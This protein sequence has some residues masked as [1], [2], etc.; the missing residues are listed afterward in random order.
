MH[1]RRFLE[2]AGRL[3]GSLG[4]ASPLLAPANY[5]SLAETQSDREH[6][7]ESRAKGQPAKTL[8][9]PLDSGWVIYTDPQNIGRA[10]EW[11][12]T[13]Q[14]GAKATRVPSIIQETHPGY[15]GVVWYWLEFD[16]KRNPW[17]GGRYLI[18]FNAVDYVGHVWLNG[19]YLGTHEGGETPFTLDATNA[20][21]P[22]ERNTLSLRVLNPSDQRID[23]IVLAET[24]HK[25]K[26]IKF[27]NGNTYDYGGI[28][29]PVE[30]LLAPAVRITDLNVRPD[31]KT[32]SLRIQTSLLN[33]LATPSK[34]HVEFC[35]SQAGVNQPLLIDAVDARVPAR[36]TIIDHEV[37]IEN[38]RL[39]DINDPQLYTLSVRTETSDH[40]GP[41]EASTR[42][43]FRDFR[44]VR[45]YFR[46]NG[47]RIL[48]RSTHT[49]NLVPFGQV[50]PPPGYPDLLRRDL[51]YA[52]ASGFNTVRFI[53]G[54]A[55]PYQL[56]LCD[57]LGLMVYEESFASWL[58]K[59]SP[60]MKTRFESSIREMIL[61][62]RNHASLVIWGVLNET[63]DGPVF[64]EGV[65][66]LETVRSVDA[67]RLVL[68]SSGRFDGHLEV[69]S[70]SNPGG[71]EWEAAW[72]KEAP[73]AKHEAMGH[74]SPPGSGDF[75]FYPTVPQNPEADHVL[76]T[77]GTDSKPVFLS[78]Y[79]IGSMMDVIHEMKMFV[80][81]GIPRDAEDFVLMRS[82]AG[83]FAEDWSRFGMDVVY[84]NPETMLRKSQEA[85]AR[86][87]LLGFNLIRSNPNICGFNLT[88]M[89]DHAMTG[90]GL[91]RSWRDW[92]PGAF[93]ATQDGWA[94]VRWCLFVEP[95]HTY[96]GRPVT[97]EAVL[98]NEDAIRPGE[99][100]V[101]FRVWGS[102][103][104][105]WAR[106]MQISVP[107]VK[108]GE[109]GPLALPVLKENVIL[110]AKGGSYELVPYI[111]NG[112]APPETSWE[113]YLSDPASLPRVVTAATAWHLPANVESW[114]VSRG[115]T[116][117]PLKSADPKERGVIL[118]GDVSSD[119]PSP[120]EWKELATRMA[121]GSTVVFLSPRAF[122]QGPQS[123]AWMPLAN[124]GRI[125][126]F[127]DWL[128]H[129]DCVAKRHPV[130]EGLQG[131]GILDFYYYG[132]M[133]PT[134]LF[135][136][137]DPP[138][139]VI[140]AAFAAGYSTPGGYA[141]GILLGSYSFGA[142]EFFL[143]S[144]PI[145][146]HVDD[147]PVADRLLLNLV[148]Y[149]S[150]KAH[151][152]S[153]AVPADFDEVLKKIGYSA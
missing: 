144:F 36:Q 22:N 53:A 134:Y 17:R 98:A 21:R 6:P 148:Q 7:G 107:E 89:L 75:H 131:D 136:G 143:N 20:V 61:R 119:P 151:G 93:D 142:G 84:P 137:Q 37:T 91:W 10:Q 73:G 128:Y 43:G 126:Q 106:D 87:R 65:A 41:D 63:V 83:R 32:G 86:H 58:L 92:K 54:V 130:F 59:D 117:K 25:N 118:V 64:R 5:Q 12:H 70:V 55:Y 51:V 135:D 28:I 33:T 14:P 3:G 8:V 132:P 60:Q 116:V 29:G 9:V 103:G 69:G 78:E 80:Q 115:A 79:G 56:D 44:V 31:W 109:D 129:K 108:A 94:P 50:I 81:A 18:R 110:N 45:G 100:P 71:T 97:L 77:L 140:A 52:K 46:L 30:L 102:S 113:F 120:T 90:E 82:M 40:A 24:P 26:V 76:R 72:G 133:T 11:F 74:P 105:A 99:Y 57:E 121:T 104:T 35:I 114:L 147:H 39:W 153:I 48:V 13:Q 38:H 101:Q 149:A 96:V 66:A 27:S 19:V 16:V 23:G 111:P 68:L 139:E 67:T 47:R 15:H 42:F 127:H 95:T 124:K 122:A 145:L 85:M 123:T 62:D 125:Y 138:S 2:L 141:S 4:L 152:S 49:G 88:G 34:V 112:V 146:D 150:L 1:R